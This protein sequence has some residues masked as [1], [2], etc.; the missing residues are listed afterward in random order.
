MRSMRR[1]CTLCAV[2][3][4]AVLPATGAGAAEDLVKAAA[5]GDLA[6]V[7]SLLAAGTDVNSADSKGHT[8]L[9]EAAR[10]GK[11]DVVQAL[12]KAGANLDAQSQDGWT[13]AM[14]AIMAAQAGTLRLLTE[15][16]ADISKTNN[17][18]Q[19]AFLI[20][21]EYGT[22]NVKPDIVPILAKA[23]ADV[24][25]EL[26]K[27][28]VPLVHA[29]K[30]L[31]AGMVGGLLKAK[32]DPDAK[33][34]KGSPAL[35]LAA[36]KSDLSQGVDM[37]ALLVAA[38]AD[39][40]ARDAKGKSALEYAVDVSKLDYKKAAARNNAG[41]AVYIIASRGADTASIAAARQIVFKN[42]YALFDTMIVKGSQQASKPAA[43][44]APAAKAAPPRRKASAPAPKGCPARSAVSGLDSDQD[45]FKASLPID[46]SQVR[47]S[48]ALREREGSVVKV[49]LS[50]AAFSAQQMNNSMVI[51]VKK[52]GEA[53]VVLRFANG[54]D[55]VVPGEYLPA[56]GYG[57]PLSVGAEVQVRG[58]KPSGAIIGIVAAS[59]RS[60]GTATITALDESWICG[61]F[62]LKGGL[63]STA[64]EFVA[65]LEN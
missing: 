42:G 13:A 23:G 58:A 34:A 47:S 10:T 55:P 2:A 59:S 16:G 20:A 17:K 19:T 37:T 8:A 22:A 64:G 21:M 6:A 49:F 1:A 3:A 40:N 7:Q 65:A 52:T 56:A 51:P 9:M 53:V 29:V 36:Q 62:R 28:E 26:V 4:L 11:A 61:S 18:G 43:A 32:A 24:N 27:G 63:G 14:R 50:N 38:G 48:A 35:V 5:K 54:A 44:S 39:V 30:G 57:K 45:D 12:I 41:K 31:N 46:F 60:E 15:A 33:D 25:K